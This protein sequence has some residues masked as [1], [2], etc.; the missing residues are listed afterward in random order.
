MC[1]ST[2]HNTIK[3]KM[4][5]FVY[6]HSTETHRKTSN[7]DISTCHFCLI[8]KIICY[9]KRNQPRFS[10]PKFYRCSI[11]VIAI[12]KFSN[13]PVQNLFN[14]PQRTSKDFSNCV[15]LFL[16]IFICVSCIYY[17]FLYLSVFI[18]VLN[19]QIIIYKYTLIHKQLSN[20]NK[21]RTRVLFPLFNDT[22]DYCY[23]GTLK[24]RD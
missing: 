2:Y 1:S 3:I 11:Y 16:W 12:V 14:F 20:V 8:Q 5:K 13:R 4:K 15:M 23:I 21:K 19:T 22:T 18:Y 7:F 17:L 9:L 24:R 6:V 10:L